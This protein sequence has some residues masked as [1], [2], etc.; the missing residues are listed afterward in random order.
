MHKRTAIR[1][2]ARKL[3]ADHFSGTEVNVVDDG[4]LRQVAR[5][6]LPAVDV[7]TMADPESAVSSGQAAS[8][9]IKRELTLAVVVAARQA[10]DVAIED[11]LDSL[12]E[13]VEIALVRSAFAGLVSK[14]DLDQTETD[15]IQGDN[16]QDYGITSL[17]FLVTYTT[18]PGNPSAPKT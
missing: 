15:A 10:D 7:S 8:R 9:S 2:R 16:E 3:L 12:A 17:R 1:V 14:I 6:K 11:E 13:G 4:N 5:G 18:T